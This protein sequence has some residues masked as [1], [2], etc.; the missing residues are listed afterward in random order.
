MKDNSLTTASFDN[1]LA[2]LG[3]DRESAA[4][5]YLDLRRALFTFFAMRGAASPDEMVAETIN[6]VA[7]LLSE[8]AQITAENPSSY[9]YAVARDV[10]RESLAGPN[11]PLSL[12]E[13]DSAAAAQAAPPDPMISVRERIESE[14]RYEC[15]E[16]CLDQFSIEDRELIVSYYRFSGGEKTEKRKRL[17]A[18]LGLP[19]NALRQKVARLRSRL[20]ECINNCQRSQSHPD[21]K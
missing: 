7:G 1:L 20:A 10:W 19:G 15:L 6:R 13:D 9:F 16:K 2:F 5:A 3:P 4:P 11:M 17:A 12:S 8:G 18:R 14:A 21:L